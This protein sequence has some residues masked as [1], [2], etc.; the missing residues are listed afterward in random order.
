MINTI[1]LWSLRLFLTLAQCFAVYVMYFLWTKPDREMLD[2]V[3]IMVLFQ[4]QIALF[5]TTFREVWYKSYE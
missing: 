3:C 1:K 4:G 2:I 5:F